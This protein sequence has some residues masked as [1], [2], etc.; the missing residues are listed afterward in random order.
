MKPWHRWTAAC[1]ALALMAVLTAPGGRAGR[2][3]TYAGNGEVVGYYA[4]WASHSGFT[5]DRLPAGEL[6]QINYAFAQIDPDTGGLA[7]EYEAR[8][9]KNLEALRALRREHPHLDL[10]ISVG[11]WS[12][13][14]YFSDVAATAAGREAFAA[15]CASFLKTHDLDGVDLDWEYPV[16]GASGSAGRPAD[17]ENFTLLLQAVRRALDRLE[18]QEGREY[19][20]SVAGAAGTWYLRNIEPR[21]VAETVDHIFLMGYDFAG[22]WSQR[23][24]LNAPMGDG[25]VTG[26]VQAYLDSGIPAE[27]L[28]LGI[29]LYGYRYQ[30]VSGGSRGIGGAFD[31]AASVTWRWVKTNALKD[32]SLSGYRRDQVPVLFGNRTFIS[33]EDPQSVAAKAAL[34]AEQ[35][36]GGIGFW[37]LSQDDEGELVRAAA[38]AFGQADG[39]RD[40]AADAWYASAVEYVRRRGLMQGVTAAA[41][42]PA[43][44]V[45]RGMTAAILYR[46][47]GSPQTGTSA[48][49]DVPAGAYYASAAAWAQARGVVTG[50]GDGTFRPDGAVTR[51][52]LAA[53]LYR[54]ARLQGADTSAGAD[55]A[56][57]PD[58]AA[59]PDY[60]REAL[61]WAVG[62]G[63]LRGR[64]DGRLDGGG[65]AT[66]AELAV[67]L[68]RFCQEVLGLD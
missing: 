31:S 32:S 11:G 55:L 38:A 13:S 47:A 66:R 18:R 25:G 30:G 24:G 27:K 58:G 45:S 15:A 51:Q 29:P 6:T 37:E 21:A 5:P 60:A 41:F 23:T 14:R 40:V 35:S 33:Y 16:S 2:E 44:S 68:Q 62:A 46:L 7:L 28:V 10:V 19:T 20:L 56:A 3:A 43:A 53:M 49:P 4:A 8:D 39:F 36:L 59:V 12:D 57:Y 26:S 9:R 52:Q 64:A 65:T 1:C 61:A 50:Y 22:P 34:A 67:L 63:V 54:Y 48:F 42:R 17:K